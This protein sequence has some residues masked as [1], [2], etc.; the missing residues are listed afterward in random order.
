[1]LVYS[2]AELSAISCSQ[3]NHDKIFGWTELA[4]RGNLHRRNEA[5]STEILK[6][7]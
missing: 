3:P 7:I 5:V 1:M 4:I 2:D 6:L